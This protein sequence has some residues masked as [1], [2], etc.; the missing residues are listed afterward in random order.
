MGGAYDMQYESCL[1]WWDLYVYRVSY[2][3]VQ[4]CMIYGPPYSRGRC[5]A[6]VPRPCISLCPALMAAG[7]NVCAN[8]QEFSSMLRAP[9]APET[10]EKK[11]II[12]IIIINIAASSDGGLKPSA[13]TPPRWHQVN[14]A[15]RAHA[16]TVI[17]WHSGFKGYGN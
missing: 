3:Y 2:V 10:L 15:Q 11:I 12:I 6:P 17:L 14:C 4:V 7:S 9:K 1:A 16:F 5:R 8:F 13:Q